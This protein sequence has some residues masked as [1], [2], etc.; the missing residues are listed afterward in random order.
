MGGDCNAFT[1]KEYTTFYIRLLSEHLPLGLDILS[2]IMWQPALRPDDIEAERTVILDEILMHADEPTDL[3]GERWQAALFPGH[4]LGRDTLGT[5]SSVQ[6]ITRDDI[7]AFFDLHYRPSNMVVSVAGDC[8]HEAVAADLE[9]RFAGTSGG[10]APAR[11]APGPDTVALDVVRRST[12]QAHLIYGM[13][14]VSRF[15][16]RRWALA[17]LNHVL[18]GGLSSRLFQKVRE[19]RGLAYSVWSERSAYQDSGSLAVVVGTAPEN[20][21]EVLR[22]V[23]A[24]FELLAAD[25]VSERELAVAKGNLRAEMLLS[26]EDSGARMS[27]L[28]ASMLL[29]GEVLSVDEVLARIDGI[30]RADVLEVAAELAHVAAHVERRGPLRR[31]ENSS[32]PRPPW[33][34][35]SLQAMQKVG[36]V[37]AGGRMGQEV[38]RA[39]SEAADLELVAAIDPGHVGAEVCGRTIVGEVNALSDLGTEVVVDFTIAEAVRHN[40]THY[41]HQGIHAVIGTSGLSES[42]VAAMEALFSGSGTGANL[43]VVPN[44]AIGAVLLLHLSR[45]AAPH[46]DGVEIIELHHNEKRDAPSGTAMHTAAV[47]AAARREAGSDPLPADPTTDV[48]LAGARGAEAPDGVHVHSV[49][50]PGLVA[51]EEV[52]FGAPGQSLSIRHDS[53]DRR[54]FMPGVL[55]AVRAVAGRPGLTVGLEALLGL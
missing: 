26:G 13:R 53:Y 33:S 42:D 10:A 29:H 12:E 19:Q 1:T 48:V 23:S 20:V 18:G 11:T 2:D 6:R 36:V 27:R 43:I 32:P 41:A 44:F 17:V 35:G 8:T 34:P 7:R 28:G 5:A 4:A 47:I 21:D 54:S 37:G 22:I 30:G 25:G 3:V 9:R 16:E 51:H 14:S 50:L 31:T 24:E 38:C 52:I 45:I 55:L 39:V 49:R 46:M 15:D 40:V